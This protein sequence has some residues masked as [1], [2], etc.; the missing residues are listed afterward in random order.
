[1]GNVVVGEKEEIKIYKIKVCFLEVYRLEYLY[2]VID[3]Y[4][5]LLNNI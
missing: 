3:L 2:I 1:M 4:I 5:L